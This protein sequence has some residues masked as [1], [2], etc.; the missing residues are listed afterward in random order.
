MN[1]TDLTDA[2]F[3]AKLKALTDAELEALPRAELDAFVRGD[4]L[5]QGDLPP[6]QRAIDR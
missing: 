5:L 4:G 3:D 2:Q 6:S 1:L